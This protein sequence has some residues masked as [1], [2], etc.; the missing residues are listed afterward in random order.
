MDETQVGIT[1]SAEA[2][3]A[4][5]G[6]RWG[7]WLSDTGW[8]WA[9]RCEPLNLAALGADCVPFLRAQTLAALA[10]HIQ[11]QEDLHTRAAGTAQAGQRQAPPPGD[12]GQ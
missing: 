5:F 6:G 9:A 3:E 12:T 10:E 4:A 11:D 2:I 8:W 7:V 1:S